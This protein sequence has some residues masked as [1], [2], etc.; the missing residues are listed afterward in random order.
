M[1]G[2]H[3][4]WV[5]GFAL[6]WALVPANAAAQTAQSFENLQ[7]RL[8]TGQTV[9]VSDAS[10]RRIKGKVAVVDPSSLT[11]VTEETTRDAAGRER[12]TWTGRRTFV[13]SSID[14]VRRPNSVRTGALIGAGVGGGLALWDY[15]IDPSEPSNAAITGTL[16]GLGLV[17][18]AGI[19]ALVH[20]G[21]EL[22]Y[23]APH[24]TPNLA[25]SPLI[26]RERRGVWVS[27]RF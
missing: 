27:L 2:K 1:I 11:L 23:R 7:Q 22:V 16:V 5:V 8:K 20:K 26:A 15:L 24:R 14:E 19:D 17:I 3:A 21:G 13:E 18:G 9:L 6:A 25:V 12:R 10:G 4:Y